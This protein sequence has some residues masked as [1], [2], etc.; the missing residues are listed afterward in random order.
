MFSFSRENRENPYSKLFNIS[1]GKRVLK[2]DS[3]VKSSHCHM[4]PTKVTTAAQRLLGHQ[5]PLSPVV[6]PVCDPV[7]SLHS[8]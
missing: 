6:S 1:Q 5:A 3:N 4:S 2:K 7:P 8:A